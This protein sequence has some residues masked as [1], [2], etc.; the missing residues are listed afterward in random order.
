MYRLSLLN[1]SFINIYNVSLS[2][3]PTS[4]LQLTYIIIIEHI[5]LKAFSLI[6]RTLETCFCT[7]R[8]NISAI[9]FS[10]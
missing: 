1:F 5:S 10:F 4:A 8:P 6:L 2:A 7:L 9:Y 3:D